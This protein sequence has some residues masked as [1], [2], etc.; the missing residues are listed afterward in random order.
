MNAEHGVR[1]A[2]RLLAIVALGSNLG[3]SVEIVRS[4]MDRLQQY[5]TVP[6]LHSS[7]WRSTPVNCP[8]ESPD[9]INA[10]AGLVPRADETPETLLDKLQAMEQEFG[11]RPRKVLNE[12]RPLDLD[13]IA[14]GDET[15]DCGQ[16]ILPHPRAHLRRFVMEPLA[17]IAPDLVLPGQT[18]TVL[19]LLAR[20]RPEGGL[21]RLQ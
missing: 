3:R 2:D 13:L 18:R 21:F 14:F 20:V 10:V 7:L 1:N 5:S 9:F 19:E 11:R 17:E 4:A 12:A 15:R 16:L 8:P 6:M